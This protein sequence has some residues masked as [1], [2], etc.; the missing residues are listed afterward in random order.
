M[1]YALENRFKHPPTPGTDQ[2]TRFVTEALLNPNHKSRFYPKL[3]P[4]F[5]RQINDDFLQ[6]CIAEGKIKIRC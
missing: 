1:S 3:H 2:I 6:Q 4:M 5:S